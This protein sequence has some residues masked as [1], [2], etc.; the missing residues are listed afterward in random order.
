MKAIFFFVVLLN[1]SFGFADVG[2]FLDVDSEAYCQV[3]EK[4]SLVELCEGCEVKEV[5]VEGECSVERFPECERVLC[6]GCK[7]DFKGRCESVVEPEECKAG[8]CLATRESV[9]SKY[10]CEGEFVEGDCLDLQLPWNYIIILGFL[11]VVVFGAWAYYMLRGGTAKVVKKKIK[12]KQEKEDFFI[13]NKNKRIKH[14]KTFS[15]DEIRSVFGEGR[16]EFPALHAIISGFKR[17][18]RVNEKTGAVKGTDLLA[19]KV[20]QKRNYRRNKESV[21]RLKSIFKK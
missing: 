11:V 2:C 7:D 1:F 5:W 6:E 13:F 20:L 9:S 4:D 12:L 17:K 18:G 16:V 3:V 21:E 14:K 15:K 10:E 19:E 8:C